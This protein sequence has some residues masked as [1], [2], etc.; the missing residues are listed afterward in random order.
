MRALLLAAAMLASTALA[1]VAPASQ[2]HS[3]GADNAHGDR[4][5]GYSTSP[6]KLPPPPPVRAPGPLS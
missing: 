4:L 6:S 5:A 3:P 2:V 1:A